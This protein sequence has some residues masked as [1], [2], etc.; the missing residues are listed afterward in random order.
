MHDWGWRIPFLIAAPMGLIGTYLRSRTDDT[1][2]FLEECVVEAGRKAPGL[3]AL[4]RDHRRPL[5]VV[6]GL[7]LALHVVYY[8]LLS[9]MTTYFQRRIGPTPEHALIAPIIRIVF[10]MT[11]TK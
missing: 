10:F 6:G 9:Y 2:L 8:T 4:V 11:F 7:V 1:P 3:G 5:F